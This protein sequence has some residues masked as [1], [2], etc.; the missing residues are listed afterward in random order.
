MEILEK[1]NNWDEKYTSWVQ[2]QILGDRKK[3]KK[4]NPEE[5]SIEIIQSEERREDHWRKI[6]TTFEIC[7]TRSSLPT[8]LYWEFQKERRKGQKEYLQK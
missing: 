8:Y 3:N 6:I 2:E 1:H 7:E 4:Q 5:L